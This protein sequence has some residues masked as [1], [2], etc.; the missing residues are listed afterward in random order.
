LRNGSWRL[1][2]RTGWPDNANYQNLVAWCWRSAKERRVIVVNLSPS[3]AQGL[4]LLPWNDLKGRTWRMNDFMSA[5][6]FE[7]DGDELCTR[8]LYVDLPA[9]GYHVFDLRTYVQTGGT[10][11]CA[12]TTV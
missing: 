3:Q 2:A 11:S 1:C 6:Q 5:Q 12:A 8:G 10:T 4:V 7:R 9:W